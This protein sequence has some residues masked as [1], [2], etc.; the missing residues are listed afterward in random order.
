MTFPKKTWPLLT[1]ALLAVLGGLALAQDANLAGSPPPAEAGAPSDLGGAQPELTGERLALWEKLR[2]EH[3]DAAGPLLEDLRD[4]R[5]IY[6]ALADSQPLQIDEL[7]K[8]VADLRRV[9]NQL[10]AAHKAYLEKLAQNG[11]QPGGPGR[12]GRHGL[13]PM[14]SDRGGFRHGRQFPRN[15]DGRFG[16]RDVGRYDG[17]YDGRGR[18]LY[19]NHGNHDWDGGPCGGCLDGRRKG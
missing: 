7:R 12:T 10:Q 17:H 14:A 8:A 16:G 4:Q 15:D 11:F 5:L 1:L 3:W 18:R 19:K 13:G 6:E 2:Q 9:R